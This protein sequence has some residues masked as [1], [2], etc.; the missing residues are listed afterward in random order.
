MKSLESLVSCSAASE[1]GAGFD[2]NVS[3]HELRG[4]EKYLAHQHPALLPRAVPAAPMSL[5]LTWGC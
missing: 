1:R 3:R 5:P 2:R 4:L